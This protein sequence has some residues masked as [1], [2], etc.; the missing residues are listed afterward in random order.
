MC[1]AA[2][3]L[4]ESARY[5][6]IF[7]A[8]RDELHARATAPAGWWED[9][10]AIF[11]GRDL[12][13]GGSWL[14]VDRSGRLAAVTNFREDPRADYSRSRGN[15]VQDYLGSSISAADYL[16]SLE[17]DQAEYGPYNLVLFD[18]RELHYA[19]NRASGQQLKPGVHA[20]SN[21][22]LGA[23][24]PKI[25]RAE[26]RLLECI[27]HD[28]PNACLFG[29][30]TDESLHGE[31]TA[32]GDRAAELRSTIFINDDRYGTRASTVI[33][34]SEHGE[35]QFTERRYAANGVSIGE[36]TERIT[37]GASSTSD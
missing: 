9:D 33:L 5:P 29:L 25:R 35:L 32:P 10:S 20:V 8:N 30:L 31:S 11:G 6:F 36:T 34:L 17:P 3:A 27:N 16:V 13:A 1:L 21:A 18:G 12:V 4:Q 2:F 24:W 14:A 15:I 22:R 37:L 7:A 26:A 23:T 19:S 28:D